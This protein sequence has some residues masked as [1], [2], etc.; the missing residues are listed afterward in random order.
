MNSTAQPQPSIALPIASL[1]FFIVFWPLGVILAIVSM[2]KYASADGS[3]AKTLSII[4]VVL[5]VVLAVPVCGITAAIA[6]PNFVKFQCRSK[7]SEAKGNLKALF[8]AEESYR[9]EEDR[10]STDL[11]AIN[12]QP[13][14]ET[15]RYVYSVVRADD[16]GFTAEARGQG[17][18]SRDV[19][20][21]DHTNQLQN[22]TNGCER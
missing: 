12:F 21:I 6:I 19:W 4:A 18:M 16:Q 22:V 15:L 9:A 3:T 14:G 5:N 7:Q 17:E 1:V 2:V 10:Y 20:T 11:A 13:R 8:V